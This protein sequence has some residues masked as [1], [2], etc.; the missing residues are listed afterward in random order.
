M[1]GCGCQGMTLLEIM[2]AILVLGMVVTMV[3]LS[4]SGSLNIVE[5]TRQQG[6]LY[7]RAQVAMQR[8]SEDLASA[9]LVESVEFTGEDRELEANAADA[10]EF[11]SS[12]HIIFD[13]DHDHPGIAVISYSVVPDE[14]NEGELLLLRSDDLLASTDLSSRNPGDTE[15]FVLSDQLRSVNFTYVDAAGEESDTWSTLVEDIP[16]AP[17]RQLPV[18]VI[19]T[20]EYWLDREN[21]ISVEFTTR[22]L[23]PVGLVN[24]ESSD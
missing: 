21:E 18:S 22:V 14:E 19:C 9:L 11:T 7:Y 2:L 3:S 5:A 12:S 23:I 13:P 20:L 1:P 15:G 10:L 24:A 17:E 8:I 16:G 6:D 4:L